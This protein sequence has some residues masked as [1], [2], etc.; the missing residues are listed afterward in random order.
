MNRLM[1]LICALMVMVAIPPLLAVEVA[2][3]QARTAAQNWVRRNPKRMQTAFKSASAKMSR[4]IND[5]SGHALCHV[6]EIEGGGFVVTSGDTELPP[7]IAFSG[8]GMLDVSDGRNP[9]RRLI[10]RDML[11][12][13]RGVT[14]PAV[15]KVTVKA[16]DK[17]KAVNTFKEE[18]STLLIDQA[19]K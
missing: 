18:W 13:F 17:T 2:P 16:A 10:E 5:S 12:R 8:Q 15:K 1:K 6:V 14:V 11:R 9:L 7:V 19:S 3:E 4:T